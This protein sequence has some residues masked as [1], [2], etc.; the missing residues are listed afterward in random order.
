MSKYSTTPEDTSK[1]NKSEFVEKKQQEE[2]REKALQAEAERKDID[3][4]KIK[5]KDDELKPQVEELVKEYKYHKDK[6]KRLSEGEIKDILLEAKN[7]DVDV[8]I[9]LD[10]EFA[11]KKIMI[12]QNIGKEQ[13]KEQWQ[14]SQ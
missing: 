10:R 9:I 1:G 3:P 7:N 2:R 6:H 11:I 13:A 5:G 4:S 8:S 12:E 14:E